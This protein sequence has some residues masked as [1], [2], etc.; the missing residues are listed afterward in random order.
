LENSRFVSHKCKECPEKNGL[1]DYD[2]DQIIVLF[3]LFGICFDET[4]PSFSNKVDGSSFVCKDHPKDAIIYH[5]L[6]ENISFCRKCVK[7]HV[8]HFDDNVTDIEES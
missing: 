3:K 2:V 8:S 5:C 1:N 7:N 6:K 4:L